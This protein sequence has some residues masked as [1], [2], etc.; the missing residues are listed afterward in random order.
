[1]PT[2]SVQGSQSVTGNM[3]LDHYHRYDAVLREVVR[4]PE[5]VDD[6][7]AFSPGF[8]LPQL[9]DKVREFFAAAQVRWQPLGDY[10]GHRVTLLDLAGNPE[11]HTTKTFPSLLMVARAV[12]H[13][14]RTGT[15]VYIVTP[16]SA[17]KG[18]AL[19]DAVLRAYETGLATPDEL[20][21]A[22]LVP[23]RSLPKVRASRLSIDPALAVR[24]PVLVLDHPDGG[25][26]KTVGRDF[27]DQYG[28]AARAAGVN[29]WYS[30]ALQNYLVADAARAFVE[31]ATD[32]T[33]GAQA[34]VHAHSVSSAY[35]LLGYHAGRRVLERSGEATPATR[36]AS[37]LVQHLGTADMVLNLR[38]GDFAADL[39]EYRRDAERGLYVQDADPSFPQAAADLAEVLDPT[40]YT[41]R[42]PTSPAMNEI[43]ATYGG[44]GIVVS[45]HECLERY[46]ALRQWISGVTRP[47][48]ADPRMLREWSLVMALTGVCNAVDRSLIERATDIVV[49]GSGWYS[50]LD[51][52]AL[53]EQSVIPVQSSADVAAAVFTSGPPMGTGQ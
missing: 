4:D 44:A 11:T 46:A 35:G 1:M 38:Y 30:L 18:I 47:L 3:I 16:T 48:P 10:R 53:P 25:M 33:E 39:P 31:H 17:N 26:V 28:K 24:N 49:H 7:V 27:V 15:P 13:V 2:T 12:E 52:Q 5:P 40:F 34:R 36:P 9:S 23:R 42:P 43:I 19:R 14:R 37:L 32:P 45:L 20:R 51:Y 21:V 22:I 41:R 50:D 8:A 29:L 6:P